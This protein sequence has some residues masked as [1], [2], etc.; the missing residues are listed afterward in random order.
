[1]GRQTTAR[2]A[3]ALVALLAV[4]LS[5][6]SDG[7]DDVRSVASAGWSSYGGNAQNSN[8]V[9]PKVGEL[10]LSWSRPVGGPISSPLTISGRS[11]VGVTATTD[12]GCNIFLF[13]SR[14]GRKNFCKYFGPGIEL[15]SMLVDQYDNIYIGDAGMFYG[16]NGAGDFRWRFGVV[17]VPVSAKFAAPGLVL[18]VSHLGQILLFNAQTGQLAAPG[19]ALRP[20]ADPAQPLYGLGDCVSAGPRCPVQAPPAVDTS[21]ERF[22][23]N[24]WPEG[25]I[26]SEVRGYDYAEQDGTRSIRESWTTEIPGGVIGTPTLSS[27]GRTLYVFNR[28]GSIYAL[29][30]LTGTPKW[31]YF[32]DSYGFGTMTVSPDGL[33][34]PTGLLNTPLRAYRDMGDRAEPAWQRNDLQSVSLSAL[35]TSG[36]A[37]TVVRGSGGDQLILTEVNS[38]D[39]STKR[40]FALPGSVGFTTGVAVSNS[41][42][43][44]TATNLGEVYFYDAPKN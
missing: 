36:T 16:L 21:R 19:M 2:A 6:C 38:A 25:V 32:V 1:M 12:G 42:Q 35:T 5:A 39:G 8:F 11:N 10:E 23:L 3:A 18:M 37:W 41:G 31:D 34:I 29:D 44:A 22:Y 20:N 43:V 33:I 26:A 27:D 24:Y 17:G 13:D 28:L 7:V 4:L 14:A 9:Y 15:N 40:E 30:A